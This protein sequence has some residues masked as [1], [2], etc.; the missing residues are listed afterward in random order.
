MMG[1][2]G[3]A[4]GFS[5]PNFAQRLPDFL[6]ERCTSDIQ[7]QVKSQC[8]RFDKAKDFG[9]GLLKFTVAAS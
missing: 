1:D 4:C 6:L 8:R 3:L 2:V 5:G 7:R 9:D